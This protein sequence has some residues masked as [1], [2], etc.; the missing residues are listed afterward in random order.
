MKYKIIYWLHNQSKIFSDP[1]CFETD[2]MEDFV[3]ALNS[4]VKYRYEIVEIII[5]T[6][7]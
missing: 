1:Q 3:R 4:A 7:E 2:N 6:N 5:A